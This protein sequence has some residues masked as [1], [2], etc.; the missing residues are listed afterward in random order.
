MDVKHD[1]S[2]QIKALALKLGRTPSRD[3]T[4]SAGLEKKISSVFGGH[5]VAIAAVGLDH[6]VPRKTK[7]KNILRI[8]IAEHIKAHPPTVLDGSTRSTVVCLGDLHKPFHHRDALSLAYCLIDVIKPQYIIQ[9][10]DLRDMYAHKK[11]PGSRI[12]FNPQEEMDLATE[13]A[14]EMWKTIQKIAPKAKCIQILGNH[15]IRPIKRI[16]ELYPEGM[17]FFEFEKFFRFPGV[18]THTDY[19]TPYMIDDV[20]YIHGHL[21]QLGAHR[22]HFQMNIV[23]GH[24]HRGGVQYKRQGNKIIWELNAGYLGDEKSKTAFGYTATTTTHWTL[25]IGLVDSMGP[26]FIPFEA[27]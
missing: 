26:R 14:T 15:D 1:L 5:A 17:V 20:G 6:K 22:D 16:T 4:R 21:S 11:F 9:M 7:N 18:H 27:L 24:S 2:C 25:G 13:S 3:D 10:G 12:T 19:R 23:V 8:D